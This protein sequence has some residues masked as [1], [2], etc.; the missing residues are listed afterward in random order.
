MPKNKTIK[1]WC[2]VDNHGNIQKEAIGQ[3]EIYDKKKNGSENPW[4]IDR[5]TKLVPCGIKILK[6]KNKNPDKIME[7]EMPQTHFSRKLRELRKEK[8]LS[9]TDVDRAT[10]ISRAYLS[11]LENGQSRRPSFEIVWRLA[12]FFKVRPEDLY[13]ADMP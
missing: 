13:W 5:T 6:S 10:H 12:Q 9:L 1:A 2:E 3:F 4:R 11:Q 8:G 7:E